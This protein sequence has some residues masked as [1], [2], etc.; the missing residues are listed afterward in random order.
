[1]TSLTN[2]VDDI[3]LLIPL[4]LITERELNSLSRNITQ[5]DICTP[6]STPSST[7]STT[8]VLLW[9]PSVN[10][11]VTDLERTALNIVIQKGM[12]EFVRLLLGEERPEGTK[13]HGP[14][15]TPM[16]PAVNRGAVIIIRLISGSGRCSLDE[17]GTDG[18]N[19]MSYAGASGREVV[20]GCLLGLRWR[21]R[22]CTG[23]S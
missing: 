18:R 4:H 8:R 16:F 13:K 20:V 7:P 14:G 21:R 19:I 17:G 1:M 11:N 15:Q 22:G 3:I 12:Y 23:C 6:S 9:R 5:R 2:L 10:L